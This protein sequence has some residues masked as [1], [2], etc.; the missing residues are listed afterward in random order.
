MARI[1][2]VSH[3]EARKR[4]LVA[5]SEIYRQTLELEVQNLRLFSLGATRK[6]NQFKS[7]FMILPLALSVVGL[8]GTV[9]RRHRKPGVRRLLTT[10]LTAWR[11]YRKF[12]P[13]LPA[14]MAR[15]FV[16]RRASSSPAEDETPA[17]SI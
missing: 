12:S 10:W 13:V 9:F 5:K 6:L 2:K 11:F 16:K 15:W 8:S 14:L 17:A 7:L 3:I 4:A 1:L